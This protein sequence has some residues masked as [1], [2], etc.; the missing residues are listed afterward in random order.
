MTAFPF[1]LFG[2]FGGVLF[3]PSGLA[4]EFCAEGESES[5]GGEVFGTDKIEVEVSVPGLPRLA[6]SYL[7]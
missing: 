1:F 4:T 3:S 5:F 2:V 7:V 6:C